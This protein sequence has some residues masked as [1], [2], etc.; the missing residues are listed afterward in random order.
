MSPTSMFSFL[1]WKSDTHESNSK[2]QLVKI[3]AVVR[4]SEPGSIFM[5]PNA[6]DKN[7]WYTTLHTH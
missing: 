4:D 6:P 5:S 3:D 1:G 2:N 7:Q